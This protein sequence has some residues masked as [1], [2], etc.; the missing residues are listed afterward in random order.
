MVVAVGMMTNEQNHAPLYRWYRE[1]IRRFKETRGDEILFCSLP[2]NYE[3]GK[4]HPAVVGHHAAAKVLTEFIKAN[5]N[6]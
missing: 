1:A 4:A 2:E 6:I 5:I 3:G